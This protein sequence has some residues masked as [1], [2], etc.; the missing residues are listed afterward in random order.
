MYERETFISK[1]RKAL[2]GT[3]LIVAGVA[4]AGAYGGYLYP[5]PNGENTQAPAT[6]KPSAAA[7]TP[8][9]DTTAEDYA[10]YLRKY[11]AGLTPAPGASGEVK[12]STA[13]LAS[14]TER[15][16]ALDQVFRTQGTEAWLRAA[17]YSWDTLKLRAK[18][19]E[20]EFVNGRI[21]ASGMQVEAT[22]LS[23]P[24]PASLTTDQPAGTA[25]QWLKA[26]E[27]NPSQIGTNVT[28]FNGRA[29]LWTDV[30]NWSPTNPG[31]GQ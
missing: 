7:G 18:Q 20:E 21:L 28:G 24:W 15:L 23:A 2:I 29:T 26:A 9:P 1:H 16:S 17:G 3:G 22:N 27:N 4:I 6:E 14:R 19:P 8:K 25:G 31:I 10:E 13:S 12:P 30:T 11:Y 5:R